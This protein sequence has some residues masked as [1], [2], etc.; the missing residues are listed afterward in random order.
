MRYLL[1]TNVV[2]YL[3]RQ[4]HSPL[5]RRIASLKPDS[6]AISVVVAAELQYG[7]QKRGSKR[8][9]NQL[10]AVLSAIKVLPLEPPADRHYGTIRAELERNGQPIGQNDLLIAAHAR[11]LGAT[12]ITN[13]LREFRRIPGLKV[14]DWHQA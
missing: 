9:T 11:A 8:L 13:N 1:D 2:S 4:P 14:E 5:A 12:L 7:A 3:V 10:E 6:L